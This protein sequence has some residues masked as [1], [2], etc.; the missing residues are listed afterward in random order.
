MAFSWAGDLS[1]AKPVVKRLPVAGDCYQGQLLIYDANAGGIVE[2]ATAASAASPDATRLIAG[3]CTAVVTSPTWDST[4]KAYM[5]DYDTTQAEQVANDPVGP[6][7]V[8]VTLIT[9]TTLV[10]APIYDTTAGTAPNELAATTTVSNGLT[11][12]TSGF[13]L[14]ISNGST[15]YCRT[16]A[17]QGLYRKITT[18]GTTTQTVL[19]AF[20]YAIAIGDKFTC[21]NVKEGFSAVNLDAYMMG[22][23]AEAATTTYGYYVYVHELNL[24]EAGKEYAVLSFSTRHLL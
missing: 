11:F 18:A 15:A 3:I 20:P 12:V 19:L 21:V 5:A 16:G 14:T 1:G 17:N 23:N 13:A 6:C 22:L 9:P 8:D 7:L 4:Y 2:A 10:K 24:A